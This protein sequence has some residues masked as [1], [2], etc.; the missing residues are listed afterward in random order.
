MATLE[1]IFFILL[2]IPVYAYLGYGAVLFFAVRIARLFR[3]PT[4]LL[5]VE[6]LPAVTLLIAAYNEKNQVVLKMKNT[7]ELDYP[8]DKLIVLWVTD[9]S[10]DGT[11][12]TVAEYPDARVLHQPERKGKIHAMNRAMSQVDTPLVVFSDANTILSRGSVRK[13]VQLFAD[14]R[15]GCVSGEKRI[16]MQTHENA[17]AAGEG[18][19]WKYESLLKKWDAELYSVVGAAGELFAVR[20]ELYQA[21]PDDTILDDFVISLGIAMKGYRIGYDAD[22]YAVETGSVSVAEE[23]KRKVRIS[24]GGIQAIIRLWPLLNVLKYGLLSFQYISH[25][26]LRWTLAPVSLVLLIPLNAL[27]CFTTGGVFAW[28]FIFQILFYLLAGIG[29]FFESR[30]IK[31]K[32]AFVP[33]Y[34]L[35]MNLAVLA[36]LE[37]YLHKGQNVLWEKAR[38]IDQPA[39]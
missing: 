21:V 20:M 7:R 2:F 18:I 38:R 27:L 8:K 37:R 19:Y 14:P 13:I 3:K 23:L 29:W 26:V 28:L 11:D 5:R 36:G 22:A 6:E 17:S 16:L 15:I 25:R 33:Y 35:V 39:A 4:Q 9:G 24:A 34:F 1:V 32:I 30:K 12:R 10:D 31:S